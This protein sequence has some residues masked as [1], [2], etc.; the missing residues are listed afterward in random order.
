MFEI[1]PV[2]MLVSTDTPN[3]YQSLRRLSTNFLLCSSAAFESRMKLRGRLSAFPPTQTPRE[4]AISGRRL[5]WRTS[6]LD[7]NLTLGTQTLN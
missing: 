6:Q 2:S 1:I 5:G 3:R 4:I 7:Y